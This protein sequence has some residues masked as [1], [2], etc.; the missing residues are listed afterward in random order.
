[1]DLNWY[2]IGWLLENRAI[3]ARSHIAKPSNNI[4]SENC[5]I[6][7]LNPVLGN[8]C[9][10]KKG[11]S[12]WGWTIYKVSNTD[13]IKPHLSGHKFGNQLWLHIWKVNQ[14]SRQS[15]WERRCPDKWGSTVI[16]N[17]QMS[18]LKPM[19]IFWWNTLMFW[20]F[21]DWRTSGW[22]E[23]CDITSGILK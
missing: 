9:I 4:S 10:I 20:G 15:V 6:N 2:S 17:L 11:R 12:T 14:L 1:M 7:I 21:C 8:S 16:Q 18:P 22:T 3:R 19:V 23:I 13:T 5:V